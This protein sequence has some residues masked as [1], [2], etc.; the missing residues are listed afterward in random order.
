MGAARSEQTSTPGRRRSHENAAGPLRIFLIDDSSLVHSGLVHAFRDHP[1]LSLVGSARDSSAGLEACLDTSLDALVVNASCRSIDVAYLVHRA[2]HYSETGASRMLLMTNDVDDSICM[3]ADKMGAGGVVLTW[4]APGHLVSALRLVA[5]GY[6]ISAPGGGESPRASPRGQTARH[7]MLD[8]LTLRERQ[9]LQLLARGM[10]N[11]EIAGELVVSESTV[12]THVQ[13]PLVKLGLRNRASAVAVAYE[14]GITRPGAASSTTSTPLATST[15]GGIVRILLLA[16]FHGLGHV[17]RSA[18]V[19]AELAAAGAEVLIGTATRLLVGLLDNQ[20]T[21]IK[22]LSRLQLYGY[23]VS[24]STRAL[25]HLAA[26]DGPALARARLTGVLDEPARRG[27]PP[28]QQDHRPQPHQLPGR[29]PPRHLMPGS[30]P[31]AERQTDTQ[32]DHHHARRPADP[33]QAAGRPGQPVACRPGEHAPRRV[34]DQRDQHADRPE[35]QQL[36]GH[37]PRR[38]VDELRQHR[39]EDPQSLRIAHPHHEP[40]PQ[41]PARVFSLW[42]GLVDH[43]QQVSMPPRLN[44]QVHEIQGTCELEDRENEKGTLDDVPQPECHQ[45]QLYEQ[46]CLVPHRRGHRSPSPERNPAADYEQDAWSRHSDQ[47]GHHGHEDSKTV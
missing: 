6:R 45:Y 8:L 12:K 40:L 39:S 43:C 44:A 27:R 13:N 28:Q 36:Y 21:L 24:G 14:L 26:A 42:P 11:S 29:G 5:R 9:V 7:Q 47:H 19:G 17:V 25:A 37:I 3:E 10:K 1:D 41:N 38:R 15:T 33:R 20:Q 2:A 18:R 46:A 22:Q 35:Q 16:F 23:T 32:T 31:A 30:V 4:E 34:G